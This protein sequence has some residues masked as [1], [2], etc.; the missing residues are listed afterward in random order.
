MA[1]QFGKDMGCGCLF[2]LWLWATVGDGDFPSF[3]SGL[4]WEMA[5][6]RALGDFPPTPRSLGS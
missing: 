5:V 2:E 1:R 4:R 6:F 3:G